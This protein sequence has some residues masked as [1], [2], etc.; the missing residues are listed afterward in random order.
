MPNPAPVQRMDA[1]FGL[2]DLVSPLT[3]NEFIEN[4]L[5]AGEH[6]LASVSPQLLSRLRETA[7]L[8]N[9]RQ[10]IPDIDKVGLFGPGGFR[11][12]VPG[13]VA[14]DFYDRGDTLYVSEAERFI[15]ELRALFTK[16]LA[17]LGTQ[18]GQFTVELFMAR[19]GAI[20]TLHFDVEMNFHILLSGRKS[21]LLAKNQHIKHPIYPNHRLTKPRGEA[22]A[23]R[24]PLPTALADLEST[25]EI[26]ATEGSCLFFPPGCWHQVE[27]HED[28][29]AINVSVNPDRWVDGMARAVRR[30]LVAD[31]V[32]RAPI[33]GALVTSNPGLRALAE[34]QLRECA[35]AY[36]NTLATVAI[37]DVALARH[38]SKM[39]WV[40][41]SNLA[42]EVTTSGVCLSA[43]DALR[44][45]RILDPQHVHL[46]ERL[47]QLRGWFGL[48]DLRALEPEMRS[49]VLLGILQELQAEGFVEAS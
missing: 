47:I 13:K 1:E 27:M 43:D 30:L 19:R 10:I 17:G 29:V 49:D 15:P 7:A 39:Q 26:I 25:E 46:F 4:H 32:L 33:L 45:R 20:S 22:H 8:V 14:L 31:P 9:P 24:L 5:I 38:T 41:G 21:W 3:E 6:F 35:A 36:V 34:R 37:E 16:V 12:V 18:P 28:S 42:L 44:K 23:H 40:P 48:D 11:S 2:S